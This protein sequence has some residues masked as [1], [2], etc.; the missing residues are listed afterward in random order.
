[1][2]IDGP[3]RMYVIVFTRTEGLQEV[4]ILYFKSNTLW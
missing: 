4:S 3:I 1:M 2:G